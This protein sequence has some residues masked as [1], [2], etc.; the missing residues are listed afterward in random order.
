MFIKYLDILQFIFV[1]L[2]VLSVINKHTNDI[3]VNMG[4]VLYIK[5]ELMGYK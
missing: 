4:A 5:L 1:I 3:I 2:L